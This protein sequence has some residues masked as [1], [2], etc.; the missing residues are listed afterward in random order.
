MRV[1]GGGGGGGGGVGG[2]SG[3]KRGRY[4][5]V[6]LLFASYVMA[7]IT[8]NFDSVGVEGGL[9]VQ[10]SLKAAP[11]GR[12]GACYGEKWTASVDDWHR[13]HSREDSSAVRRCHEA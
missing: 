1:G 10:P 5:Y 2:G 4:L 9:A 6:L 3:G 13:E 8:I 7:D 12:A 11:P